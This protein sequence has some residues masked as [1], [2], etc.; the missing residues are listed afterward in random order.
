ML[1]YFPIFPNIFTQLPAHAYYSGAQTCAS[2][3]GRPPL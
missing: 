3:H 2:V 1:P